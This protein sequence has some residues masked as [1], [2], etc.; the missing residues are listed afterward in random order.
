MKEEQ[1]VN[2]D[3]YFDPRVKLITLRFEHTELEKR[4][5]DYGRDL[6]GPSEWT[7]GGSRI[8]SDQ[9]KLPHGCFLSV[10]HL[11]LYHGG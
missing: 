2:I 9:T 4:Y 10:L 7:T 5:R 11:H 3:T 1:E 6:V 8:P